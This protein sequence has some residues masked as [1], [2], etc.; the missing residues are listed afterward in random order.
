M[1]RLRILPLPL[2]ALVPLLTG[3][4]A[5]PRPVGLRFE[6][7][8]PVA[9]FPMCP[10]EE[11]RSLRAGDREPVEGQAFAR[12][13]ASSVRWTLPRTDEA[14]AG[15][16]YLDAPAQF[17]FT[18]RPVPDLSR[19]PLWITGT[20]AD[21]WR[22]TVRLDDDVPREGYGPD[23]WWSEGRMRSRAWLVREQHCGGEG[24]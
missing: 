12:D 9:F 2:V 16:V 22:R 8:R 18:D 1:R 5:E 20:S 11:L 6:N 19:G 13:P 23:E 15:L 3:C 24:Y 4:V 14:R 10:G 21:G 7:G 17:V